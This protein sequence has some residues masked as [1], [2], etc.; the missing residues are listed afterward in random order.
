MLV[1]ES[2]TLLPCS[3]GVQRNIA[4]CG[5]EKL[6]RYGLDCVVTQLEELLKAE[7]EELAVERV[8]RNLKEGKPKS[9]SLNSSV[10]MLDCAAKA[11]S[12]SSCGKQ[13]R[14]PG[15]GFPV[16]GA[17]WTLF[18]KGS[19]GYEDCSGALSFL[20][21]FTIWSSAV[22]LADGL[23]ASAAVSVDHDTPLCVPM[24]NP[25]LPGC[26]GSPM[27]VKYGGLHPHERLVWCVTY[28]RRMRRLL[29]HVCY[30]CCMA[31]LCFTCCE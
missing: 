9:S 30:L 22:L 2:S 20:F 4:G 7:D 23:K 28:S 19:G 13:H 15:P 17:Q 26:A 24:V 3:C 11:S 6:L 29:R 1:F 12:C 31:Y 14:S 10:G 16:Q 8:I 21:P 27:V 25:V 5:M 18:R